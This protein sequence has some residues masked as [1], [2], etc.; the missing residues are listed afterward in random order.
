[1][2][3]NARG[4]LPRLTRIP[5]RR[6]KTAER[7]VVELRDRLAAM[8]APAAQEPARSGPAEV[9]QAD[10]ISVLLNLGYERR[11][12]REGRRGCRAALKDRMV[13]A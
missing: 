10:V 6:R 5:R 11:A 3:R 9:S 4:D 8:Q 2:T 7:M 12:V 13:A 1:M